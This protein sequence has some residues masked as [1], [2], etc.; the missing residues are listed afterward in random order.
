ASWAAT[1]VNDLLVQPS[2]AA[3]QSLISSLN[4]AFNSVQEAITAV[5]NEI[6]KITNQMLE[7]LQDFSIRECSSLSEAVSEVPSGSGIESISRS[8]GDS[9]KDFIQSTMQGMES[10]LRASGSVLEQRSN[11]VQSPNA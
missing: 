4:S 6:A 3:A 11:A 7:S 10:Q 9:D 1:Q 8:Q 5:T 2:I